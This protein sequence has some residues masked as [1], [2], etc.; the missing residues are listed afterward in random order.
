MKILVTGATGFIGTHL[1]EKLIQ[2]G[3]E[4]VCAVR[5]N[6]QLDFLK[7]TGVKIATIDYSEKS[8]M[9]P[10][11][12]DAQIVYHL[13]AT[14]N[15]PDWPT[16]YQSNTLGTK[17]LIEACVEKNP[18]MKKF[19]FVSSVAAAGPSYENHK[20]K[21]DEP[22]VPIS[23][24][25]RS[26]LLAEQCV[27]DHNTKIPTVIVRPTIILGVRQ[28]ELYTILRMLKMGFVPV[29]G[30]SK[31]QTSIC[32]V[33][34]LINALL[35]VAQNDS[36]SGKMYYVSD[37]RAYSWQ[38]ILQCCMN[39]LPINP[40]PILIPHSLILTLAIISKYISDVTGLPSLCSVHQI[41]N[42]KK[43][44]FLYSSGKI[45]NELGFKPTTELKDGVAQIIIWYK[46]R[47]ML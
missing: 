38:E 27:E 44:Y 22:S 39:L 12:S 23:L 40:Y 10:A 20:K 11:L 8:S 9:Y 19:V 30:S 28:T 15:V 35:L 29:L 6:S 4:V 37:N 7:R 2:Q 36:S 16:Y 17:Y 21:E 41:R 1:V 26:K 13:A 3:N 33:E 34:D 43:N 45:M 31:K 42:I 24:Y 14:I 46:S 18:Y 5:S 47:G 25:G 32:F